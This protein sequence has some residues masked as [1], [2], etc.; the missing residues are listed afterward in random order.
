VYCH[1]LLAAGPETCACARPQLFSY[2]N[3]RFV[4]YSCEELVT[5]SLQQRPKK[6]VLASVFSSSFL[7]FIFGQKQPDHGVLFAQN[8][9]RTSA[10]FLLKK[11]A[12][13]QPLWCMPAGFEST[14]V[15]RCGGSDGLAP[16]VISANP[17]GNKTV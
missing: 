15:S 5:G 9:A 13:S 17:A 7:E 14:H 16:I 3:L 6:H 8:F 4:H 2:E 12:H 1:Y 11:C 10:T